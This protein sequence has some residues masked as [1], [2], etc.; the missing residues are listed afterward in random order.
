MYLLCVYF[1]CNT[2]YRIIGLLKTKSLIFWNNGLD[3]SLEDT[4]EA[5]IALIQVLDNS[6]SVAPVYLRELRFSDNLLYDHCTEPLASAVAASHINALVL[7][8]NGIRPTGVAMLC[9][10]LVKSHELEALT[11]TGA[12]RESMVHMTQARLSLQ[13]L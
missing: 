6:T 11:I 4:S 8:G 7:S 5:V 1:M 9:D 13:R 3:C 10:E 12:E 2:C